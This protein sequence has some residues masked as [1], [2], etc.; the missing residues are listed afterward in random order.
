MPNRRTMR[1]SLNE[2][3]DN[4]DFIENVNELRERIRMIDPS[5]FDGVLGAPLYTPGTIGGNFQYTATDC[6][7]QKVDGIV[8]RIILDEFNKYCSDPMYDNK[9]FR[10]FIES[11]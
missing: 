6:E 9:K 10:D 11:L 8:K 3:M 4:V 7:K 2:I 5:E 1:D